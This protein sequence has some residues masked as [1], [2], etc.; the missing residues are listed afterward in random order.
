MLKYI[1]NSDKNVQCEKGLIQ[2][3]KTY[4]ASINNHTEKLQLFNATCNV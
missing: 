1:Y 4:N 2:K 3:K